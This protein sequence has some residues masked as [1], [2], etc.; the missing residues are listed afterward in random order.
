MRLSKVVDMAL[1]SLVVLVLLCSVPDIEAQEPLR[2]K[3]EPGQ[4]LGYNMVQ[5]MTMSSSGPFGQPNVTMNQVM[6]MTWQVK[7]LND[8]GEAVI[9]QKFDRMKMKMTLPPPFGVI[10]YDSKSDAAPAGPAAAF[11]P[12]FKALSQA[13]F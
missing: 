9:R 13:E 1:F 10:E 6:E 11:A 2:W 5:D 12:M 3:F 8:Q 4:K 7:E